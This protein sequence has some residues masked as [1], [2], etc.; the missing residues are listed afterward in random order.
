M[1]NIILRINLWRKR[2][3]EIRNRQKKEKKRKEK[4]YNKNNSIF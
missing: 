2:R 3:R 1:Y 4:I